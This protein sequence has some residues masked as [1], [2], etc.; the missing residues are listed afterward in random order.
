MEAVARRARPGD[1]IW[2]HDYQL[3]LLPRMLREALPEAQIG[4]FLHIPFPST[5]VFAVLPRREE[6]LEGL[7]GADLVAFH[8]HNYLQHFRDALLRLLGIESRINEVETGGRIVRLEALPIGI[9]PDEFAG[10]AHDDAEVHRRVGELR[11]QFAGQRV[12]LAVDRLDYTKGIP[13]AP[14]HLPPPARNAR[15]SGAAKSC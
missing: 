11:R 9:A 15:A 13:R 5:D 14:A 3:M 6:I 10:A 8:T 1:L 12:L 2:V 4:F 7:L